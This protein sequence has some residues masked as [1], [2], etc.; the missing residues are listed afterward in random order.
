VDFDDE[1][2]Q[3]TLQKANLMLCYGCP[4]CGLE[5]TANVVHIPCLQFARSRIPRLSVRKLCDLA[6]LL[7]RE[8]AWYNAGQ[9]FPRQN[10]ITQLPNDSDLVSTE[11]RSFL[12]DIRTKLPLDI[13]RLVCD[14]LLPGLFSSLSGCLQTSS[15]LD[16]NG[17][18][19]EEFRARKA[20]LA[21]MPFEGT[22]TT[23]R[24]G[25]HTVNI[26]GEICV[27]RITVNESAQSSQQVIQLLDKPIEGVQYALGMYGMIALRICYTDKSV[28][29][30]LGRTPRK[31]IRFVRGSDLS[32]L[33]ARSDVWKPLTPLSRFAGIGHQVTRMLTCN[34]LN[35]D[36]GY[37]H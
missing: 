2:I 10:T 14:K 9:F 23:K 8:L 29:T 32:K 26:L 16:N 5:R 4:D 25:C 1:A 20:L 33:E 30:W 21:F 11:L 37:C 3:A 27:A 17:W 36:I 12:R 7:R 6:W 28:S 18:L 24:I 34:Y 31:W 22:P 15:H 13:E 35:R 19:E